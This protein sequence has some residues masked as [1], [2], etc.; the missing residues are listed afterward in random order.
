VP[1]EDND[2][3]GI[4]ARRDN[5]GRA[6]DNSYDSEGSFDPDLSDFDHEQSS[7]VAKSELSDQD[8]EG[9]F[10]PDLSEFSSDGNNAPGV[11]GSV[12]TPNRPTT[13]IDYRGN[14]D[15]Q[16]SQHS[17][18]N[19]NSG[20]NVDKNHISSSHGNDDHCKSNND[21]RIRIVV[22]AIV[23]YSASAKLS[24]Q[25]PPKFLTWKKIRNQ[26]RKNPDV[27]CSIEY[28]KPVF[29]DRIGQFGWH[30]T[31]TSSNG[32]SETRYYFNGDFF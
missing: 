31:K 32:T 23:E 10:D 2:G 7:D 24:K 30:E 4:G 28:W 20:T 26:I 3:Y 11:T 17:D 19:N 16:V 8:T 18:N 12:P 21:K 14:E 5:Q 13:N 15:A 27:D 1:N 22:K 29:L 9:S 6:E 25:T